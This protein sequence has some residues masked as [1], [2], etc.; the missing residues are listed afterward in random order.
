MTKLIDKATWLTK[1]AIEDKADAL[2]SEF[3]AG[4]TLRLPVPVGD[5]IEQRLDLAIDWCE[6]PEK[7][8]E[9]ILAYIN[10]EEREIRI[11]DRHRNHFE[12]YCGTE[13]FTLAHEVGHWILHVHNPDALQLTLLDVPRPKPF[14][15][16]A[17]GTRKTDS[18]EWQANQFASAFIMPK[19]VLREQAQKLDL[20]VW[21][22]LY[23]LK[24]VFGV[25]ITALKNRLVDLK[26]IYADGK[27]LYPSYEAYCGQTNLL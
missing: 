21:P 4:T 10:P 3:S 26:L 24:E 8:D 20:C 13:L 25:T 12:N 17:Q 16:R 11:N 5:I 15:C 9:I 27:N 22:N 23:A 6:I 14:I 7:P 18:F 2:L 19:S 1:E